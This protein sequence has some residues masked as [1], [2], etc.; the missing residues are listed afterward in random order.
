MSM[1]T[2]IHHSHLY[3]KPTT[4]VHLLILLLLNSTCTGK[5]YFEVVVNDA[6]RVAARIINFLW[7]LSCH[8]QRANF[9]F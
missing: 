8:V 9:A 6:G 3:N 2:S 7:L 4:P 5:Y 1:R